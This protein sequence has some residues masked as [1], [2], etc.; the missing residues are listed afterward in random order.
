MTLPESARHQAAASYAILATALVA[1]AFAALATP[2]RDRAWFFSSLDTQRTTYVKSL[3]AL[4]RSEIVGAQFEQRRVASDPTAQVFHAETSAL[5]GAD[6]QNQLNAL[7]A[8]EGGTLLS[9]A[10][11]DSRADGPLASI[12]VT[13]R[14]RCSMEALLR[15][16]HGLENRAPVLFVENL[17]VQARQI[18]GRPQRREDGNLDVELDVAALFEAKSPP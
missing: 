1:G 12:A 5:A 13:V 11:R 14:L 15:I 17:T 8:T 6:L 4:A 3:E 16:L 9:S 10:F 7:I 2:I 18:S